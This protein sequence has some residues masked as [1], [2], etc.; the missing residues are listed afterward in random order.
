MKIQIL[1][2]GRVFQGTPMQIVEAMH[3]RAFGQESRTL[4][5]YI[6]FMLEQIS[7]MNELALT[8]D[9]ETDEEKANA[10]VDAILEA[11]LARRL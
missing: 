10:F 3:Y 7:R 2:D 6:D 11:G 9:G 4:S 8:A 1:N 5:E